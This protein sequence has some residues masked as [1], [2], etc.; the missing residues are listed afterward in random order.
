MSKK[1][2]DNQ[3]NK[4]IKNDLSEPLQDI[5][6]KIIDDKN[7]K[8]SE[9]NSKNKKTKTDNIKEEKVS[10]CSKLFFLW[11]LIV[12]KLSNKSQLRK[13][14]IR[15]SP[16]F[17]SKEKQKEFHEEFIFIKQLW[18]GKNNKG[19]LKNWP[20]SPMIFTVLRFNLVGL[21]YLLFLLFIVQICKMIMLFFKRRIVQLFFSREQN[22]I[23]NY[24]DESF[25]LMLMKN[26]ACFLIVEL[27][28][29]LVNHQLKYGQRELTRKSTSLISLLIYDKFMMQKLLPNNMK[30]GDLI[31]YLQTD[32]ESMA[33]FFLQ[34]TKILIFPFQFI[35]YFIILYKIFGK[36]FF[37]GG[38][39][40]VFLIIFSIIVEILYI[41]NQY[42][43]LSEKDKRINF[44]SQTIK[45]IKELKLLQWEDTFQ[46]VVE[47]KRAKEMIF[48]KKRLNFSVVLLVIHWVMP[49][50]LCL[51]TI[52]A[53]VKMNDKFLE[54][55]DL[56]TALEIFD[57]IRGPIILLPDR[58]REIINAYVS[59]NRVAAYLKITTEKKSNIS[60]KKDKEY[61][62]K[63]VDS[64]IG[65]NKENILM[66]INEL[67]LKKS[68]NA[69][70]IGE[71]GSGKSCLIKSLIDRLIVLHKK[72]FIIDGTISYAS[73]TPFIVNST[74]KDNILFY[75][76]YNEE[77]Y[78]QVI[79]FCELERDMSILPAGDLTEI[80]T[81]GANISGG[82][83]SR[84]NLA[85]CV[86]KEADIY[87]FDDPISSVDS[88]V[89]NKILNNLIKNFLKN[90]TVIFA[91]NDIKYI[92]FF[93]KVIFVE[94][95]KIKFIGTYDELQG[96][97]FFKSFKKN[98]STLKDNQV[99]NKK[100]EGSDISF[101]A[102]NKSIDDLK[103]K[104]KEESE[105][106]NNNNLEKENLSL[107]K[108]R[109][110]SI[111]DKLVEIENEKIKQKGKLM[112]EEEINVG[113]IGTNIYKS[114]I[115][116]SGGYTQVFLVFTFA[117]IWQFTIIQ[118]N[119][120]LTHWS[121]NSD[122]TNDDE[123]IYHF[124][125]Y[126]LFGIACIFS[127]FLKEFLISIMNY[128]I[129][130]NFHKVMLQN[131]IDAP[132]NLYHDITPFGQIMN[133][134][135]IDLDK[136]ILFFRHF[137]ST[138]KSFCTLIG[139][140]AVCITSNTYVLFFLPIVFFFGYK[141]STYYAPAGRDILRIESIDRSPLL[142]FYS[143][144]IQGID[145]IKSLYYHNVAQK[146][147]DKFSEK[148]LGHLSIF[149]YKFGTRTFFELT[150]DLLSVA[151]VFFLFIYCLIYHQQFDAVSISLLLKYSLNISEEI[152]VMLTHGTELENS[153]VRIERCESATHLPKEN[154]EGTINISDRNEFEGNIEFDHLY[155]KYRPNLDFALKDLSLTIKFGDKIC[156][157]GRT[158]S[159]KST[160]ILGLFRLI[161]STDGAIYIN[162]MNIKDIPL[163]ILRRH[164][165]IVPQEPKIFS[166]TL[167]FNLDPKKKYSDFEIN[168]AVREVGL[169]QLM[170]ENGRDIKKKLNMKLRENGGNLS[171]G[172]KQLICMA[173]IFLRKNKIVVM[174]EATSNIDN[175][176]DLFIQDAVDKI[177]KNSTLITIAH[178]IPDLDKYDKIMVLDNGVLVE[179]DTP[180]NLLEN[181]NG[182]FKEL[183]ENNLRS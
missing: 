114:I 66:T 85:R 165:G 125:I 37:V 63:I 141:V 87:L 59:M 134:F 5:E 176:T 118:G 175:K 42:R 50:L 163:K 33:S 11:T 61:S 17:T 173:R 111:L 32:T 24:T 44:T 96:M 13:E 52:G 68:E 131:I 76:K 93:R 139:A 16:I 97:D 30:E 54:I 19:G 150:L 162:N 77:R 98:L 124:M 88:I 135:T 132:I 14:D 80:G 115:E 82:Q 21:I 45:N 6:L 73:Q 43:F 35:T 129:S 167:K 130:D 164:L 121:D 101:G 90:K 181:E 151:F 60:R 31:N 18:E 62:I 177:F 127:L 168:N 79:K 133:K 84:I 72:E 47:E 23:I 83:K 28:R 146:F 75:S 92:N 137:S 9:E 67:K 140:L 119:I 113:K 34:I 53:Y 136:S 94:K 180:N 29:F 161:E 4:N 144:S 20:F 145:T 122:T 104:S 89:Y 56:M 108:N 95:E 154:Y 116:Y 159:G 158:G 91:S 120:Y 166:G 128:N 8:L 126:T 109:K 51:S 174:D 183:Y 147:F 48:M 100:S 149:L 69:V 169:F 46:G 112:V 106:D 10:F 102:S 182:I 71:T 2:K 64:K 41:K 7:N 86:Y 142:S 107:K 39:T 103:Y 81:N 70:I 49:L 58:V 170:K 3:K 25:R 157:V 172:E 78:K 155:I 55:A 148:I 105:E 152:L 57:N 143:E 110:D 36:A 74:V 138:L 156:V 171:L 65:I 15:E 38:S 123:N 40:F 179:F 27:F 12:M 153:F 1:I 160:I 22:K 26:I 117:I 99:N 178:K